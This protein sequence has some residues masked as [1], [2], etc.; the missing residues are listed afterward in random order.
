VVEVQEYIGDYQ[1]VK[2]ICSHGPCKS[3][4]YQR[5]KALEYC[6]DLHLLLNENRELASIKNDPKDFSNI[7]KVDTHIHLAAAMTAQHLLQFIQTKAEKSPQVSPS[8]LLQYL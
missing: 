3:L 8:T 7:I 6:Y 2:Q 1:R 4:S 5:L